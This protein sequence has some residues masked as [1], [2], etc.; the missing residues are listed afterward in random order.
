MFLGNYTLSERLHWGF[1]PS[2]VYIYQTQTNLNQQIITKLCQNKWHTLHLL[3][4]IQQ[5]KQQNNMWSPFKVNNKD[6]RTTQILFWYF[7]CW[8]WKSKC[9]LGYLFLYNLF[10]QNGLCLYKYSAY[11]TDQCLTFTFSRKC[12]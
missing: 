7:Y 3:I 11:F 5:R 2:V 6:T 9:W 1:F 8:Q 10:I 4:Q 12:P